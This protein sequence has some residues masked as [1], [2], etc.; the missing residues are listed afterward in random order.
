MAQWY[1]LK[2]SDGKKSVSYT[3]MVST[4]LVCTLWLT[5]SIFSKIH[6]LEIRPFDA[7]D[8]SVWF[9]PIAALYFGRKWQGRDDLVKAAL[10]KSK[11]GGNSDG[12]GSD[13]GS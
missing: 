2:N 10:D 1:L 5:L 6:H 11:K 9:A 8:A 12:D 3:M 4:F 7:G 13:S